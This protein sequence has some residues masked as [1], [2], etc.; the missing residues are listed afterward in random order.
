MRGIAKLGESV[1]LQFDE[2]RY[3][4]AVI[5]TVLAFSVRPR[6][7]GRRMRDLFARQVLTVGVEPL[8]FVS[9]V[10]MLVGISLVVQLGFWTGQAGQSALLGPLL[11]T[12][13]MRELGPILTNTVVIV[14]SSS[15]MATELG[16]LTASG[17]VHALE[18]EG[19]DPFLHLVM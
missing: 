15:A 14:R 18:A 12:V 19:R 17:G 1:W 2:L 4:A 7:W 10:A 13:V 3:A 16:V 9:G 8:A 6:C 5:G 11:V